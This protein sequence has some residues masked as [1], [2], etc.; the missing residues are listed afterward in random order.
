MKYRKVIEETAWI[1]VEKLL[2]AGYPATVDDESFRDYSVKVELE[3]VG[4]I[5]LYYS[6]RKKTFTT[7]Y[8]E[9]KDKTTVK[10][11]KRILELEMADA[12]GDDT[13]TN[14]GY[15]VDVDGSCFNDLTSYGAIVRKDGKVLKEISGLVNTDKIK[16]SRQITGEIKAV[17]EAVKYCNANGI[18]EI[19]LYYDYNGLKYWALGQWKAN[20][21]STKY[22]R[23]FMKKQTIKIEW[24]KISSHTGVYWNEMVDKLAKSVILGEK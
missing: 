17:I 5:N 8:Q 7:T 12:N 20:L 11:L 21:I 4:G 14:K 15:E 22:Y 23:D 19:R 18:E 16:S 24:V 3:G 13:Y 6:P 1:L 2:L 10:E 9:V